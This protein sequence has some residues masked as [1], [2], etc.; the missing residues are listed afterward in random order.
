MSLRIKN[1]RRVMKETGEKSLT[2]QEFVAQCDVNNI[3]KKYQETGLLEHVNRYQGSY[4]EFADAP[5]YHTALNKMHEADEMFMTIPADIREMFR[6]DPGAFLEFVM[7]ED[8][9]DEMRELGLLPK[10]PVEKQEQ[11]PAPVAKAASEAKK[12]GEPVKA[13]EGG[14][15]KP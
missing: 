15:A 5:D 8:N 12:Q 10:K 7:N 4:G 1:R 14:E 9:E 11:E 6:N 3:M 2:K 13:T